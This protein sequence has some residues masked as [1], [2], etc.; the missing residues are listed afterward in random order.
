MQGYW[1]IEKIVDNIATMS[2]NAWGCECHCSWNTFCSFCV[3]IH[4]A[5]VS[6]CASCRKLLFALISG[7]GNGLFL[8]SFLNFDQITHIGCRN[9]EQPTG[10]HANLLHLFS[11]EIWQ[12]P[13]TRVA[14]W[15]VL[16]FILSPMRF[17]HD[18]HVLSNE[19]ENWFLDHEDQSWLDLVV[20]W[21]ALILPLLMQISSN[22]SFITP[23]HD[24]NTFV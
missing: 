16:V 3:S 12:Q 8:F 10:S 19:S 9:W 7:S 5:T 2:S 17:S 23:S 18:D 11:I 22:W 13:K 24:I 15:T 4:V 21:P 6:N 14:A 20:V 1:V